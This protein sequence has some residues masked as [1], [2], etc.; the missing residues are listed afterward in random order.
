MKRLVCVGFIIAAAAVLAT[1]L[2]LAE[3]CPVTADSAGDQDHDG[4]LNGVDQCCYVSSMPGDTTDAMCSLTSSL[5]DMNGNGISATDEGECCVYLGA[6]DCHG[7]ETTSDCLAGEGGTIV[8]CDKLLWYAGM[9]LD[10]TNVA[11]CEGDCLCFTVGDYDMDGSEVGDI[12]PFDN[13]PDTPA[14]DQTNDDYDHWGDP[15]DYCIFDTEYGYDCDPSSSVTDCGPA[16]DC[17]LWAFGESYYPWVSHV[18]TYPPDFDGDFV[19]DVCDNCEDVANPMQE[20]FDGDEWGDECDNCPWDYGVAEDGEDLDSDTDG[21]ADVCDNCPYDVN[22]LQENS[23]DDEQG[24]ACDNCPDVTNYDQHNLDS[25]S[26]GDACDN[27]FEVDN[28]DQADEDMDGVGDACDTCPGGQ[29]LYE[30]EPDDDGDDIVNSC[31]NCPD[32]GNHDQLNTDGD[33]LGDLC[34]PCPEVM[35]YEYTYADEDEWADQCDNCPAVE[36]DD[37]LDG[38]DDKIGDA[39]DNCPDTANPEQ[40]D[41]DDDAVGNGCDNCLQ[42]SN[43]GQEDKDWD[44]VGDACDNCVEI[45]NP[46][47]INSDDDDLGDE[48]DNCPMCTNPDQEDVDADGWGDACDNCPDVA[49]PDQADSDGD[50]VGDECGLLHKYTGAFAC[51]TAPV[52]RSPSLWSLAGSVF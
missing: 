27:C 22:W 6:N 24:D 9:P 17:V 5:L 14:D 26:W 43:P 21:I 19:G 18:C 42:V 13:C 28:E 44:C 52:G 47:Q 4:I 50:G 33:D 16:G 10:G 30:G 31:D 36:N 7:I 11:F 38:D 2:A 29:P 46:G 3:M 34:D 20:D 8:P 48:C 37:Q 35:A 32:V 23:D 39:C 45:A 1:P 40:K 15:C 51:G 41:F 49:N 12:G 25:D